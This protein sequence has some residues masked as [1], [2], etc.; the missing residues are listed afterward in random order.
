AADFDS[1]GRDDSRFVCVPASAGALA[2][3]LALISRKNCSTFSTISGSITLIWLL[4]G[5]PTLFKMVMISLLLI[6]NDFAYSY[7]LIFSLF[8]CLLNTLHLQLVLVLRCHGV[9]H[10]S[11]MLRRSLCPSPR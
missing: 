10:V 6:F 9:P 7:T 2:A 3:A 11:L 8:S 4:T 5:L 1:A